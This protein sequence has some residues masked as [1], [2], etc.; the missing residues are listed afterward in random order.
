[1]HS[2]DVRHTGRS[3]YNT[4]GNPDGVEIWRFGSDKIYGGPILDQNNTIYYG[5]Y[6]TFLYAL[7]PNGTLKWKT[8]IGTVDSTPALDENGIIYIGTIWGMPNYLFALCSNN[9]TIKW[10]YCTDNHVDSSPAIGNDRTIYFGDWNG[11]IH[12]LN[13]NGTLKWKYLTGN[14]VTASPAIGPDGTVYCGSHDN[15]LY[16]FYPNNGTVKWT[17]Q[18]DYWVRVNPC[19]GDDGTVYCV[20][21]DNYLYA[22]YPG[23]GT[24]KW[25]VNVGAGTNPTI[26]LD[27][28][29]YCGYSNL[30]AI[31]P[32]GTIKWTFNPGPG[33]SIRGST[34]CTSAEGI[35]YFG[36]S[37]GGEVIA[38]N[39][40]GIERWRDD[41]GWYESPPAI[42]EDGTVYIGCN[43][44]ETSGYLRAFG[45]GEL[46]KIEIQQP[47]PGKLYLF[48]L[49]VSKT[50]S[51]NTVIIGS[52]NVKVHVYSEDQ[53]E[54]IH[55][56]ID[57]TYQYNL[58]K[59]PYEWRMNHRY[60]DLFP[61]KHTITVIGYYKGGCSWSE[62]IDVVYF[63]LLK[64]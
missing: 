3:P 43:S 35:I 13:P 18:T 33:R 2:H 53:I 39:P 38:V 47:E 31:R 56:Y 8:H 57:G 52:V 42:G 10:S 50:I 16:A 40:D 54:S 25:K 9:G 61:L 12:A 17:F 45:A 11:W 5:S 48:G 34:P 59:P 49:G 15:K 64:N 14:I 30:Y 29:I 1:M 24:M 58:T 4:T 27:G 19:V 63:H 41:F 51:G 6:N 44:G 55:F 46:K 62:S 7:C 32:N 23:N 26:G 28:I 20:S 21:L 37:D 36:T 22:L 60:A